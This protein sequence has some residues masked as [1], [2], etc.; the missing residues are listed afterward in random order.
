MNRRNFLNWASLGFVAS[1]FPE[2]ASLVLPN[3]QSLTKAVTSQ[4]VLTTAEV[5]KKIQNICFRSLGKTYKRPNDQD[6]EGV[7]IF[8]CKKEELEKVGIIPDCQGEPL[9]DKACLKED[10]RS[11]KIY[12]PFVMAPRRQTDSMIRQAYFLLPKNIRKETAFL[13]AD[14][15]MQE[16]E[17]YIPYLQSRKNVVLIGSFQGLDQGIKDANDYLTNDDFDWLRHLHELQFMKLDY[18]ID[19]IKSLNKTIVDIVYAM[20]DSPDPYAEQKRKEI[21][22]RFNTILKQKGLEKFALKKD[23]VVDWGADDTILKAFARQLPEIKLKIVISN[24]DAIM[25]YEQESAKKVVDQLVKNLKIN[26]TKDNNFDAQVLIFTWYSKD[27]SFTE[28]N[29]QKYG[30]NEK[31][32]KSDQELIEK[33]NSLSKDVQ[34]KTIIVDAR[35]PNGAWNTS[36]IPSSDKFLAFGAWGTFGNSLGQTLSMAKL[37]H[38][39]NQPNKAAIQRQ[40]LLEAIAHDAFLIGYQEGRNPQGSLQVALNIKK[41]NYSKQYESAEE[42]QKVFQV[43]NQ[44]LNERIKANGRQESL[45]LNNTK[46]TFVPQLWRT[47]ESQVFINDG[48]LSIAGVY[49]ND[50]KTFNPETFNPTVAIKNVKKFNLKELINEF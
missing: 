21:T 32:D 36:T 49:V 11:E 9:D 44:V 28:E 39:Y 47:F 48:L 22:E 14:R 30:K 8:P 34:K 45:S 18:S 37:L 43:I 3:K 19:L 6:M 38:F 17:A 15:F 13:I 10:N 35:M 40:L 50:E 27:D 2:I 31:Q 41:L 1:F 42:T 12:L 24:P 33:M 4:P 20:G 23:E 29:T 46:F 7:G 26:E 25:H 16:P 5:I